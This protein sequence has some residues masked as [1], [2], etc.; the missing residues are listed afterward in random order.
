MYNDG[1]DYNTGVDEDPY[2]FDIDLNDMKVPSENELGKYSI[3]ES[4]MNSKERSQDK[5]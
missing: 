4:D 2:N 3:S 1:Y 5:S